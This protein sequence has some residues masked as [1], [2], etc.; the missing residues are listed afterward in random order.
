MR[1]C[2]VLT[3]V[4]PVSETLPGL[5]S[6]FGPNEIGGVLPG[7]T[8]VLVLSETCTPADWLL[9]KNS[10]ENTPGSGPEKKCRP[11]PIDEALAVC[12]WAGSLMDRPV[13]VR[14]GMGQWNSLAEGSGPSWE[15]VGEIDL[16]TLLLLKLF[17]WTRVHCCFWRKA[18]PCLPPPIWNIRCCSNRLFENWVQMI[19]YAANETPN[20]LFPHR[21]V[22]NSLTLPYP[23]PFLL[24]GM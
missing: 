6:W 16:G 23:P 19:A 3:S 18:T 1:A 7:G 10:L 5:G 15:S 8:Y 17:V 12:Q 21:L 9:N 22:L 2:S 4:A 20:S 24:Y 11:V 14:I 13:A